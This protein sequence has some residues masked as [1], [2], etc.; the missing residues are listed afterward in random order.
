MTWQEYVT[1][2]MDGR[3]AA[4]WVSLHLIPLML[5]AGACRLGYKIMRPR[6]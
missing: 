3:D 5:A 1:E 6:Q 4:V 2:Y